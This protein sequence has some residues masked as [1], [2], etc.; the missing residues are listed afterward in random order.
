MQVKTAEGQQDPRGRDVWSGRVFDLGRLAP[1][2][3]P[4]LKG[5]VRLA[6]QRL[7][8]YDRAVVVRRVQAFGM[9][10][11]QSNRDEGTS[12]PGNLSQ[13]SR[14]SRL[15]GGPHR[16]VDCSRPSVHPRQP[17]CRTTGPANDPML[18]VLTCTPGV[19]YRKVD[20]QIR[21][22]SRRFNKAATEASCRSD[23]AC[24]RGHDALPMD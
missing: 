21:A 5:G 15:D 6:S 14:A 3:P 16:W 23:P 4:R 2:H 11:C 9:S 24:R 13:A 7:L 22:Q 19:S 18:S 12:Q 8:D 10:I 1:M 17:S 20:T